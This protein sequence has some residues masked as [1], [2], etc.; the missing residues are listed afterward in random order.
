METKDELEIKQLY[1][2]LCDASINQD[3]DKL[4]SILADNYVLVHMTGKR[5]SKEDYINSVINGEL[6]YFESKHESIEV[7]I[8]G[9][10]AKVIG[11]TRTLAS[12]FGMSKSWWRLRQDLE[13]E[14]INNEWKI[15]QSVASTY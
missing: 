9:D 8:D 5:Q 14:K 10:T 4:N 13:L 3:I 12:P 15:V 6:K 11:K 1:I 7:Q 2:D